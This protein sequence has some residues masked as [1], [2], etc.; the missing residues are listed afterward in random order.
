MCVCVCVLL[1][2]T[3][4]QEISR[5]DAH[6]PVNIATRHKQMQISSR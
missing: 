6:G 2:V 4:C 5:D 3:S 1:K